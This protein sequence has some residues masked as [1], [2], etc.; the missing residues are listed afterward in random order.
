MMREDVYK[1]VCTVFD[2]AGEM[3]SLGSEDRRLVERVELVF[4]R[5]GLA[6]DKEKREQL[7]MVRTRIS[8]LEIKFNHNIN[9]GDGRAVFTRNKLKGLPS[10]FSTDMLPR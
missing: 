10:D 5:N 6:L 7:G 4:R 9:E 2:N 3:A 1:A 8:E